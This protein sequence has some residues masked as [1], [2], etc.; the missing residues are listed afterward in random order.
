MST[1]EEKFYGM[2]KAFLD[3][4]EQNKLLKEENML[5]ITKEEEKRKEITTQK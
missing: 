2:I 1:T 3:L 5:R 4:Q